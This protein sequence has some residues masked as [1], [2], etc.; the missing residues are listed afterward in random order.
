LLVTGSGSNALQKIEEIRIK[1]R[2]N[3]TRLGVADVAT[4]GG[5]QHD[6]DSRGNTFREERPLL[7]IASE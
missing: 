3:V 5:A 7:H 4:G 2:L 1:R 6:G